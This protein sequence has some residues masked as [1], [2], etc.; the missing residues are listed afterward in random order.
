MYAIRSYYVI[1]PF[2]IFNLE[3]VAQFARDH[4]IPLVTPFYNELN[5]VTDNPYLFQLSPSME[6]EYRLV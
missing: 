2:Y 3:V 6:E 1:G 5:L 4:R